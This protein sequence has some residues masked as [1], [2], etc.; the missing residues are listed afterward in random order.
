M[1][2]NE[3][4]WLRHKPT[5]NVCLWGRYSAVLMKGSSLARTYDETSVRYA[6][7]RESVE[8]CVSEDFTATEDIEVFFLDNVDFLVTGKTPTTESLYQWEEFEGPRT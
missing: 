4:I 6:G 5:G 7:C 2:G 1:D 8:D 3:K